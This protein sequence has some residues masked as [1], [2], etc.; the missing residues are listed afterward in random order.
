MN[1]SMPVVRAAVM[2]ALFILVPISAHAL[3]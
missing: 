3:F 1:I 2:A